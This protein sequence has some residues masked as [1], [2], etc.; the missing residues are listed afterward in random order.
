MAIGGSLFDKDGTL[1]DFSAA[2]VPAY[3]AGAALAA[4][5]AGDPGLGER[6][7][8]SAGL[9]A[10][11]VELDPESLLVCGTTGEICRVWAEEAGAA[12]GDDLAW[13]MHAA[14]DAQ[15]VRHL[16]PVGGGLAELF[17]RLAG[18]GLALGIA[19]ADS[20]A[21]ARV[22]ARALGLARN[23]EFVCGYDS[24]F[25]SKPE[26]GM[27]L[28]FCEAAGIAPAAVMVVGD[29]RRDM[30]M[31]RAAGAGMAVGVLSGVTSRQDLA[32]HADRVIAS[33]LEIE[34]VL[35]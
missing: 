25:G 35:E 13:R 16:V 20:E 11:S 18:R 19:T 22:A 14:M 12:P 9:D 33:V 23:L 2:W 27:V 10:G 8:R 4:E 30:A 21:A 3:R 24:G 29:T 34:S 7:L 1:V 32:P 6:L 28:G 15:V 17:A 5:F 31:A 26:P